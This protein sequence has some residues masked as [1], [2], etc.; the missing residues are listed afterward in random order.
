M[1]PG[2]ILLQCK[3]AALGQEET[4]VILIYVNPIAF[5]LPPSLPPSCQAFSESLT[6]LF[7][8]DHLKKKKKKGLKAMNQE[9]FDINGSSQ[10]LW[11]WLIFLL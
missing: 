2:Y 5:P 10:Y 8:T 4:V 6:T 3:N 11:I 7:L 1:L 9:C